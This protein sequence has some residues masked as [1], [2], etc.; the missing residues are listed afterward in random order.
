MGISTASAH[1]GG[2]IKQGNGGMK[3]EHAA[4]IPF[5]FASRFE[6]QPARNPED[7]VGAALAGCCSMALSLGLER[8]GSP[9]LA[10]H[11]AASVKLARDGDGFAI[12][13]IELTTEADVP[14]STPTSSP[15]SPRS[16][17]LWPASAASRSGRPGERRNDRVSFNDLHRAWPWRLIPGCP[18]RL[19][20]GLRGA[21]A[22]S[23]VD[24][25]GKLAQLG[26]PAAEVPR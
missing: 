8:A 23:L 13:S 18:G 20:L 11:T 16:P 7:L 15:R 14:G 2:T 12:T 22:L 10:I 6:G 1:W 9:P 5:S 3:P 4:E 21:A 26:I 25:V 17:G 24:L 19:R